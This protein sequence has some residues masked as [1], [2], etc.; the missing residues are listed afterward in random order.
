MKRKKQINVIVFIIWSNN[1]KQISCI[2]LCL[3]ISNVHKNNNKYSHV[4]FLFSLIMS[5]STRKQKQLE[6]LHISTSLPNY[7]V[8]PS[9]HT[10]IIQSFIQCEQ[11]NFHAS[12]F[13]LLQLLFVQSPNVLHAQYSSLMQ[14]IQKTAASFSCTRK[15]SVIHAFI[16]N[17][18][19][20]SSILTIFYS[21]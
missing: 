10:V 13:M 21:M 1:V 20:T 7:V 19:Y 11:K 9:K 18:K 3:L 14:Y 5:L 6:E 12:A 4:I 16:H 17:T 15:F 8:L 2:P